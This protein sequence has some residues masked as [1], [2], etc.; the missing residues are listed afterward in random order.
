MTAGPHNTADEISANTKTQNTLY[1]TLYM[2]W[3]NAEGHITQVSHRD[4][5][6]DKPE[7]QEKDL[8]AE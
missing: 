5:T 2:F 7:L 1:S 8:V 3:Q 4:I 6:K